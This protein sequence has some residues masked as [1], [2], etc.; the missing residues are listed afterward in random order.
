M[1]R[2]PA[3]LAAAIP[4]ISNERPDHAPPDRRHRASRGHTSA[5]LERGISAAQAIAEANEKTERFQRELDRT[6]AQLGRATD[7]AREHEFF[8]KARGLASER[9]TSFA[10]P[11]D[12]GTA[13]L[14]KRDALIISWSS[15]YRM[16]SESAARARSDHEDEKAKLLA[17][18]AR[19]DQA[20]QASTAAVAAAAP[21]SGRHTDPD[22]VAA[23]AASAVQ[24]ENEALTARLV[25]CQERLGKAELTFQKDTLYYVHQAQKAKQ[26]ELDARRDALDQQQL[27]LALQAQLLQLREAHAP[28]TTAD[29]D[30]PVN[31]TFSYPMPE[32]ISG[33]RHDSAPL[34]F[35]TTRAFSA[36]LD[37]AFSSAGL[38]PASD[39]ADTPLTFGQQDSTP[40]SRASSP[41]A[42]FLD[43]RRRQSSHS[44]SESSSHG[45]S[46]TRRQ[47]T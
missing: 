21:L 26:A 15:A 16:V 43:S 27:N 10:L 9:S 36:S 34:E 30:P 22:G 45:S 33:T 24:L 41:S 17:V 29:S 42:E 46:G 23:R 32:T 35:S 2:I 11:P 28:N 7:A 1:S 25:A 47:R 44:P 12:P 19:H 39:Y 6:R 13:E 40:N 3:A 14:L 31:A 5:T 18:I 8:I 37:A 4:V 38:W 20:A